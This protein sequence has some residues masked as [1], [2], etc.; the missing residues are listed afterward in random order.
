MMSELDL[1]ERVTIHPARLSRIPL[2]LNTGPVLFPI[3][4][5]VPRAEFVC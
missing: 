1:M 5:I 3:G 2:P 4:C